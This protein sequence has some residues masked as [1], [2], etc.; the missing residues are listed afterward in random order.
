MVSLL[1][2][3]AWTDLEFP[4]SWHDFSISSRNVKSSIKAALVMGIVEG[5]TKGNVSTN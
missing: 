1:N 3:C 2:T 5:S 4:L